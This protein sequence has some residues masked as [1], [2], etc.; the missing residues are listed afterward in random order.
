MKSILVLTLIF[1]GHAAHSQYY[2][3]DVIGTRETTE[4]MQVYM[5]NKVSRVLLTSYDADNTKSDNFFVEQEFISSTQTLK[6]STK[7]GDADPTILLSWIDAS[8]RVIK[9]LDSTIAFKSTSVYQYN[10]K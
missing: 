4:M 8:G 5:N 1:L 7:N 9:T 6:T 2:Y 10:E 3:K